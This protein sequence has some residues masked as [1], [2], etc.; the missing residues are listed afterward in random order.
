MDFYE[1]SRFQYAAARLSVK[2]DRFRK[3]GSFPSKVTRTNNSGID[4]APFERGSFGIEIFAPI[5]AAAAPVFL[6][7][8]LTALWTYVVER[9]FKPAEDDVMRLAL[10]T[11]G[12]LI[13]A[14]EAQ[15]A[16]REN[17]AQATLGLLSAE[18][19]ENRGLSEE[20]AE[21]RER[22][23][24][25]VERR[26]YLQG[27]RD[28]LARITPEQDANL[29]TMAAPLLK[30]LAVPLRRSAAQ[31]TISI[32]DGRKFRPIL[33]AN[34]AMAD[35]V[36]LSEIDPNITPIRID[37]IQ[38]NKENGWGKF[39]NAEFNGLASFSV[40]A[41]RKD[42]LQPRILES[43]NEPYVFVQAYY[44]RSLSGIKQRIIIVGFVEVDNE[45]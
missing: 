7:V 9:V 25:E 2:L 28:Q 37:I 5:L 3:T 34:K 10:E 30:E 14:Y 11:Q 35:E 43:M 31:A 38:Y 40:S 15:I 20:N 32:S 13:D 41:D 27:M 12:R 1:S 8:P 26:A 18:L 36:E 22:L 16:G 44:V 45:E 19:D 21:L 39:R 29:V 33:S 42:E 23:L 17:T 6:E 24:A 4:L